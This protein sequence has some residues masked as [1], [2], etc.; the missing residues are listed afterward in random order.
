M[1]PRQM[2]VVHTNT[3][4]APAAMESPPVVPPPAARAYTSPCQQLNDDLNQVG[5]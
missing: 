5:V 4:A 1:G 2:E 3:A